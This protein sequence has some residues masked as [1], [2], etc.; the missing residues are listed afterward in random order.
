MIITSSLQSNYIHPLA[1]FVT[2]E[3]VA[4][5]LQVPVEKIRE[6][7]CWA[8]VI[9]V[10]GKGLSRFVS[11]ADLPPVVEATPPTIKDFNY[12]R[13][14]R[15]KLKIKQAPETW[16]QFYAQKFGQCLDTAELASWGK[17]LGVIKMVLA[18]SVVTALRTIYVQEKSYL[19]TQ[20]IGT[21]LNSIYPSKRAASLA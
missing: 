18:E 7:R 10:V 16:G 13:K 21:S 5:I 14:R 4:L 3:S 1:R 11:Y 6:I 15:L 8:R 19:E 20:L 12:W 9:L 17:L 2:T